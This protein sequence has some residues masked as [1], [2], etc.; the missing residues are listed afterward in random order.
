MKRKENGTKR[1][2]TQVFFTD[3]KKK[4]RRRRGGSVAIK[5][6]ARLDKRKQRRVR[7]DHS[8]DTQHG[9]SF[10]SALS[11]VGKTVGKKLAKSASTSFNKIDKQKLMERATVAGAK[12]ML[13]TITRDKRVDKNNITQ[14][15]IETSNKF[16]KEE[17]YP[18]L[19]S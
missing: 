13:K 7:D 17:L 14:T 16:I 15:A 9:G 6:V 11:K 5:Q 19:Q 12:A 4:Y 10:L 8:S 3:K 2:G 1:G 18:L